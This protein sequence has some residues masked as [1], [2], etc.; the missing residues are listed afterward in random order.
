MAD[1]AKVKRRYAN[2]PKIGPKATGS[3]GSVTTEGATAATPGAAPKADP[4][5][6]TDGI[7]VHER[8]A[9]ERQ[10]MV[11]L[12]AGEMKDMH[13]RHA[14]SLADMATRHLGELGM[15]PGKKD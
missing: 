13:K 7:P 8:Q 6:G 10:S 14:G 9:T 15:T 3:T 5:A 1:S 12:H 2:T 4:M 11:D